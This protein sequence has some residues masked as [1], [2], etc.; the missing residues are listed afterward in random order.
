MKCFQFF[1]L[2][3]PATLP[4]LT[5]VATGWA[6]PACELSVLGAA[7]GVDE[8]LLPLHPPAASARATSTAAVAALGR[9]VTEWKGGKPRVL[10]G[11]SGGAVAG[12][13]RAS[14]M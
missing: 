6:T 2:I 5:F 12:V 11:L 4:S 14:G 8:S 13:R 7:A 3:V 1:F 9:L 10:S